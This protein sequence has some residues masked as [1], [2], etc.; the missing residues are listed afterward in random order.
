MSD[1]TGY[2]YFY[3]NPVDG[4][5]GKLSSEYWAEDTK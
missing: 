4:N 5:V 3:V 1:D 2:S